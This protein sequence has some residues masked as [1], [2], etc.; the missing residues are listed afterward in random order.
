MK[1]KKSH[2]VWNAPFSK[3]LNCC[4]Y[5]VVRSTSLVL[6][7]CADYFFF[8]WY[9]LCV[10]TEI[11]LRPQILKWLDVEEWKLG[12]VKSA[13]F[14]GKSDYTLCS[15]QTSIFLLKQRG[16]LTFI[17]LHSFIRGFSPHSCFFVENNII[18]VD[19]SNKDIFSEHIRISVTSLWLTG[20]VQNRF[21]CII[22]SKNTYP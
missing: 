5:K 3:W 19:C 4:C 17:S 21:R 11:V 16:T 20:R 1:K 10:V 6:L 7:H 18:W 13:R 22:F 9:D 12:S 2:A 15:L 8:F 14:I